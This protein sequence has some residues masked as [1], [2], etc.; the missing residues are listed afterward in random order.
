[1]IPRVSRP[2]PLAQLARDDI[3]YVPVRHLADGAADGQVIAPLAAFTGRDG[4]IGRYHMFPPHLAVILVAVLIIE[5]G[6]G[7]DR[8]VLK[9]LADGDDAFLVHVQENPVAL[10]RQVQLMFRSF[11]ALI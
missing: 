5:Y 8:F 4:L 3:R 11:M 10:A 1:M 2:L 6:R 7:L 9:D